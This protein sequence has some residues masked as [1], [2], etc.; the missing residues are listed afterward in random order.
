MITLQQLAV[1]LQAL[2]AVDKSEFQRKAR[3][4]QSMWRE[5]QGIP[6]GQ[7]KGRPLGSRLPM[8]DAEQGLWNFLSDNVKLVVRNEVLDPRRSKGKLYK[9]PRIFDDLLSSQPLCFN[10]FAELQLDPKL[11]TTVLSRISNGRIHEVTAIEFEH[12]PGRGDPRYLGDR[13]AFD[14]FVRFDTPAGRRGFVGIEVKYHENLI[15]GASVEGALY[16]EV[17]GA[18][19]C[20][21]PEGRERLVRQ[22]LGQ[23]WRDHLLAGA[24]RQGEGYE[25][26]YLML[27]HPEQ[28]PHCSAAVAAYGQCL[29]S[30]ESFAAVTLES[31]VAE[32][33]RHTDAAWVRCVRGRYLDFTKI[34][35]ALECAG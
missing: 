10:L 7:H 20:F 1:S 6:A 32:I 18:M 3:I 24:L 27:L 31:L 25:D 30:D 16:D 34:D 22:P 14:V 2:E 35:G 8:P 9:R 12:S 5:A 29:A 17:A 26:G 13:S 15:S 21:N 28:N 4:L 33:E 19:G 11:A 23:L